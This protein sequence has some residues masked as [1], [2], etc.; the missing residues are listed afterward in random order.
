MARR[1]RRR[2]APPP[3]RPAEP[4]PLPKTAPLDRLDW[5]LGAAVAAVTAMVYVLTAARDIVLGD[6]PE[7]TT[8]AI[9]LGV[10]HPPGYPLFTML[11]HLF[12][13]WPAGPLPFR[14]N[15]L[16]A[17]CGAGAVALVYLTALRVSGHRTASA[18][19]SLVLAFSPLYWRW[20]L[21]AEVF[22]LNNLLAAAIVYLLVVWHEQPAR[23][24]FL[25][26]AAFLSGLASANH[27]TIVL[28]GPAVLWLLWRRRGPWLA[29]PG[30]LG[31][32]AAA[33]LA[34]LLPY[35]YLP[36]A[37]SRHP[38]WNWGDPSSLANFLAVVTRR[39]FGSGQLIN[40]PKFQGGSPLDRLASLGASF[41]LLAAVL[42]LCGVL[43][44]WRRRRWYLWFSLLAFA[45][46]GPAFAAYANMNISVSLS[47]YVLER[48]FLLPQVV[49]APLMAFGVL[50]LAEWLS[51]AVPA[52]RAYAFAAVGAAVLLMTLGGAMANY[53]G[54]DQSR[55]RAARR[56]AEDILATLD[57]GAVLVVNGDE[58]IMP[59]AYLQDVEGY[60]PDVAVLIMP[61]LNTD[62]YLPQ[63]RRQYP[64]LAIPFAHYNGRSGTGS[65]TGS[66]SG[67]GPGSGTL[68]ALIEANPGR[69][70]AMDNIESEA[71]LN[72]NYW[73]RRRGLVDVMEPMSKDVNI[74]ELIADTEN[75]F[76]RYHPPP[77]QAIKMK[78]LEPSILS[79][80][81]TPAYVVAQQCERVHYYAQA[82]DWY[83]RALAL[84]PS[85]SDVRESL[86]RL[87]KAP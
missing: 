31:L 64:K 78:S 17:L 77:P 29:R 65:G 45:F 33:F 24:G 81:A 54:I 40:A 43:A 74:D 38:L 49:L 13:L 12:S 51:S 80:Y 63:L 60:R 79:H 15:L 41:G 37:A 19:A 71:S 58:V 10:A 44:A 47:R 84:D 27:Q 82:R 86:A 32:C 9:G 6:T 59:L 25:A 56:F 14:V 67:T 36:W 28:L 16:S 34:G 55:N 66:G 85:L 20:S 57:P 2:A 23:M 35:V 18:C 61:L 8:A 39:H 72:E 62:W 69:A 4:K 22:P 83:R 30:A 5:V 76:R 3:A 68:K 46:A 73:F 7:L 52:L 42:L 75:L 21:V 11:G 48:F 50:G 26:A 87:D 70:F 1:S 53:A